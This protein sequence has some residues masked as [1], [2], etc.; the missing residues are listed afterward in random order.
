[1]QNITMSLS[2]NEKT[3]VETHTFP[4]DAF[5]GVKPEF[6]AQA[7][8]PQF[9]VGL[10]AAGQMHRVVS[11]CEMDR[12]VVAALVGTWI[13]SGLRIQY[14]DGFVALAKLVRKAAAAEKGEDKGAAGDLLNAAP[15]DKDPIVES[16][17]LAESF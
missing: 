13:A 17:P 1:M 11:D 6:A 15:V 14:A 3:A 9:V 2:G 7:E 10:D 5:T 12:A 16:L 8:K 4:V